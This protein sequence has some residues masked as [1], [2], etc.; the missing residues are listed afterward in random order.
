MRVPAESC[1]DPGRFRAGPNYWKV[2]NKM[3]FH[4][5][6]Q[7]VTRF[8]GNNFSKTTNKVIWLIENMDLTQWGIVAA[9]F[10]FLGFLALKSKS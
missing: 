4:A 7:T 10:V 6:S 5:I 3:D 8:L 1:N 9:V 2:T